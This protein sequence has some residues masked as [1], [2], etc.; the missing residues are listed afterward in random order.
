MI[1]AS[2]LSQPS[3]H[4]SILAL[5]IRVVSSALLLLT[6]DTARRERRR[7]RILV[8]VMSLLLVRS[9]L[10][11]PS[12][13]LDFIGQEDK[14]EYSANWFRPRRYTEPRQTCL[15]VAR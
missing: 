14:L 10:E 9:G 8:G 11:K 6:R 12:P 2:P 5:L 3:R 13:E 1:E 15:A 7:L 4:T